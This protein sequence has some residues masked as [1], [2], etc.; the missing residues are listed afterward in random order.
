MTSSISNSVR[1]DLGRGTGT[2]N[3]DGISF[4]GQVTGGVANGPGSVYEQTGFNSADRL[5]WSEDGRSGSGRS[6]WVRWDLRAD[7]LYS[8]E[9]VAA[10]SSR[11]ASYYLSTFDGDVVE[12][13]RSEFEAERRRVWPLGAHQ[14]EEAERRRVAD[15]AAR[16]EAERRE[17]ER[18]RVERAAMA[19]IAQEKAAELGLPALKGTD[20]QV[21]FALQIRD[22][23]MKVTPSEPALKK[24]VTASWWIENHR[25][26]LRR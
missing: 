10:N 11:S 16:I 18:L 8:L 12:L 20:K 6:G 14:A 23:V 9:G 19:E 24:R 5:R 25:S 3:A 1:L 2:R 21:S 13:T 15:E 22:A 4:V 7:R 17:V 26:A